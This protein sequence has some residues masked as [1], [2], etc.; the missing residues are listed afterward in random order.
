MLFITEYNGEEGTTPWR[1]AK[2]SYK[3]IICEII[4]TGVDTMTFSPQLVFFDGQ[5]TWMYRYHSL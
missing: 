1:D 5:R 3:I 2:R 4:Q